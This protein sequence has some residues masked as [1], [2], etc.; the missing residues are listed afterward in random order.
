MLQA[1]FCT[2]AVRLLRVCNFKGRCGNGCAMPCIKL[3]R[4][5]IGH[6]GAII[7]GSF[8]V[9]DGIGRKDGLRTFALL[10]ACRFQTSQK[11]TPLLVKH[12]YRKKIRRVVLQEDMTHFKNRIAGFFELRLDVWV[13]V[14]GIGRR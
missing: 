5:C 6:I 3:L 13:N 14:A 8:G 12:G 2:H 9:G 4:Q 10:F 1:V 11:L 7:Y